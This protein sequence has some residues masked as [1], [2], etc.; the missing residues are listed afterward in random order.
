MAHPVTTAE[1]LLQQ[2][3]DSLVEIT[4]LLR[5]A[6]APDPEQDPAPAPVPA[7]ATSK[8]TTAAKKPPRKS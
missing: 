5:Q 4:G 8:T 7:R 6:S 3:A 1:V 2:I